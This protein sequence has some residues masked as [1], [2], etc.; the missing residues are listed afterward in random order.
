MWHRMW[1]TGHGELQAGV[2]KCSTDGGFQQTTAPKAVHF[3]IYRTSVT[4]ASLSLDMDYGRCVACG[5]TFDEPANAVYH[6]HPRC[7]CAISV[8]LFLDLFTMFLWSPSAL[9]FASF[10]FSTDANTEPF[11]LEWNT[12]S[13]FGLDSP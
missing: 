13:F 10:V 2:L 9:L 7:M 5:S 8:S 12:K 4:L 6:P 1:S 3:S 11:Q